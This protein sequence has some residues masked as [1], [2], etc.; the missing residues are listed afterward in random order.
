MKL[1]AQN[2]KSEVTTNYSIHKIFAAKKVS[3]SD[4]TVIHHQVVCVLCDFV[5]CCLDES[6][7]IGYA[8]KTLVRL[9][10][11]LTGDVLNYAPR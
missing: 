3:E 10:K 6:F 5:T 11:I 4:F 1:L 7:P 2:F 8:E 9:D